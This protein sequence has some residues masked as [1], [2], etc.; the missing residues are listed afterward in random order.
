MSKSA[1]FITFYLGDFFF[2]IIATDVMEL[3][4]D[5]KIT[6]VPKSPKTI[7]GIVNLRGEIVPAIN[8]HE[9]FKLDSSCP[10]DGSISIILQSGNLTIAAL[11]DDVGEI[12]ALHQDTFEPPP[13]NFPET[14][15]ELIVGVHKLPNRLLLIVDA[16]R[17]ASD[18]TQPQYLH[19]PEQ[20][21]LALQQ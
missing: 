3:N 18:L 20:A 1:E 10:E 14:S 11:V 8:M 2:G 13:K 21:L 16:K 9:R 4:R 12:I 17:I 19:Q 7:R 6:P 5:L 15:K